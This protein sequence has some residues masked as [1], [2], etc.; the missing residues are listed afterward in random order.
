M[1]SVSVTGTQCQMANAVISQI[2]CMSIHSES[3]LK[4]AVKDSGLS[5]ISQ[6]SDEEYAA[7]IAIAK[8]RLQRYI[9]EYQVYWRGELDKERAKHGYIIA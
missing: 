5:D 6:M 2:S 4:R 7:R 9:R 3:P 1:E 8:I